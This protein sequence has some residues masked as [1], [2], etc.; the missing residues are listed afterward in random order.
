MKK[1]DYGIVKDPEVFQENRLPAHSDHSYFLRM[2]DGGEWDGR[3]SLNGV[4]NFSYARNHGTAVPGFET[5]DYDCHSWD[6]IR[7]PAHLQTEGY[8]APQYA[9]TQ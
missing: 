2:D 7:V 1:F 3:F 8:D 6:Q 4:W 5:A 9:N